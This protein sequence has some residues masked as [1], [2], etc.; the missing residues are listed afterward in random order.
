MT[1]RPAASADAD[2]VHRHVAET[3]DVEVTV[4]NRRAAEFYRRPGLD[5]TAARQV[6]S[7]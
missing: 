4:P 3:Q 2:A 5:E 6:G 7:P 1:V